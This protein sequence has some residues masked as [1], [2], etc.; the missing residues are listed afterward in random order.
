MRSRSRGWH[1]WRPRP[2][3]STPG[4]WPSCPA[5]IWCRRSGCPDPA[6]RAEQERARWRLHLVRHRTGL[7]NRIHATLMAFGHPCP[8]AD[9]FGVAGRRLLE[10]LEL[11]EPW[12]GDVAAALR[13]IEVL[14][15][16]INDCEAALRRLG[17]QHPYVPL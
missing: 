15:G 11:P 8:V 12:V 1:R 2:I 17:T 14:D 10:G 6:V 16:E 9:L 4:C 3:G 7:K 13:L 5:G